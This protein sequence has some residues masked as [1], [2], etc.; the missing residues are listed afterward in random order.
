MPIWILLF[1]SLLVLFLLIFFRDPE[2]TPD[3]EGM[4]SPADGKI[5]SMNGQKIS[6]FMNLHNVHVNRAPLSGTVKS[7]RY[8]KGAF[9]PAFLAASGKNEKNKIT[10]ATEYGDTALTQVAGFFARRIVCYVSEGENVARGQRL[11]M[12][13]FGSRVDVTVPENFEINVTPGDKV[14]AGK[15]VIAISRGSV[16]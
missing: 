3:G 10:L 5:R 9:K 1:A 14:K 15:T 7:I 6:I 11:G 13:R 8:E 12:I 2:R 4:L 16:P